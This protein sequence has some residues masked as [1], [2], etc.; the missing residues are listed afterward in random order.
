[1]KPILRFPPPLEKEKGQVD[2]PLY[3]AQCC[4]SDITGGDE[5]KAEP[6]KR[7][8]IDE[9][10][11]G[12]GRTF[13]LLEVRTISVLIRLLEGGIDPLIEGSAHLPHKLQ[14]RLLSPVPLEMDTFLQVI[15]IG[16]VFS[17]EPI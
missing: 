6:G 11:P 7:I 12:A 15:D 2:K 3:R 5:S 16:Q 14:N 1:M 9:I 4:K 10:G 8:V 13:E 17:P